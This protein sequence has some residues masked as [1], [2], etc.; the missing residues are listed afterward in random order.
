MTTQAREFFARRQLTRRGALRAGGLGMAAAYAGFA[1]GGI[2]CAPVAVTRMTR[3][4]ATAGSAVPVDVPG[5]KCT[6]ALRRSVASGV[7]ASLRQVLQ[8]GTA[9][10]V[11]PLGPWDSAGKTGTTDGPYDSWFVGY[12]AQRSTAVWVADPGHVVKG[13]LHRRQLT[14]ITVADRY[15]PIIYGGTIAAPTW[16]SVMNAAMAELPAR[17]LP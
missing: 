7:N 15:R 4:G 17:G 11:G 9:A 13:R 5:S 8:R 10:S 12:T 3:P 1:S 14:H 2:Y 6:R 16:K